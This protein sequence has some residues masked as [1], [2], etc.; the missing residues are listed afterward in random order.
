MT[1]RRVVVATTGF[2]PGLEYIGSSPMPGDRSYVGLILPPD[3]TTDA[4]KRYLCQLC[5]VTVRSCER[6]VVRGLRQLLSLGWE[7]P[8]QGA[9]EPGRM[10]V[11]E[12]PAEWLG[13][14]FRFPDG[15]VSWHLTARPIEDCG[16]PSSPGQPRNWS[17]SFNTTQPAIFYD[18]LSTGSPAVYSPLNAGLPVGR[19]LS[20]F[21]C[22][23][24]LR[25]PW[26][27]ATSCQGLG[28]DVEGPCVIALWA[29]VYQTDPSRR[30]SAINS[31]PQVASVPMLPWGLAHALSKARYWR[32]GGELTVDILRG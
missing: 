28:I 17:R 7:E 29:S 4:S 11:Q 18:K 8:V 31:L 22:I 16:L 13:P 19:F 24:D 6:A 10:V 30:P 23:H 20:P 26:H 25:Y 14:A 32:V 9:D 2:D 3:P 15:N 12:V 5:A 27:A 21:D 1:P